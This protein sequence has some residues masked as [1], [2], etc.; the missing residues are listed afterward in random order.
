MNLETEYAWATTGPHPEPAR[1]CKW[2]DRGHRVRGRIWC[3]LWRAH[4]PKE[5]ERKGCESYVS[6]IPF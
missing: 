1:D 2:C 5:E 4:V 6:E 3:E